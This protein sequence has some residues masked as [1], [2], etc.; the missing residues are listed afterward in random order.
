MAVLTSPKSFMHI[1]NFEYH[2]FHIGPDCKERS[3]LMVLKMTPVAPSCNPHAISIF[4]LFQCDGMDYTNKMT[5][6]L[7]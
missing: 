5:Q 4:K 3:W 6:K 2:C 1:Y 7:L